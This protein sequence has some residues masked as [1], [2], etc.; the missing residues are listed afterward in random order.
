[1]TAVFFR[2]FPWLVSTALFS[3]FWV[4]AGRF[5]FGSVDLRLVTGWILF[6]L[7]TLLAVFNVRKR[8]SMLP[9]GSASVW[10][11]IHAAA[12]VAALVMFWFHT[13][14]VWP[15]GFYE[16]L[17]TVLFYATS[18][19][20]VAGYFLQRLYPQ[21]LTEMGEEIIYER[22][23]AELAGL[24]EQAEALTLEVVK[25]HGADTIA[26]LYQQRFCWFFERPRFFL[27]HATGSSQKGE[28]WVK[29]RCATVKRYLNEEERSALDKLSGLALR[30]NKIDGHYAL[31][32]VM[33]GWLLIHVPLVASLSV[34]SFWHLLLVHVYAL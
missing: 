2:L 9:L 15:L 29:H 10:L 18:I 30:K 27:A 32:T 28:S 14:T 16:Q 25:K 33:K 6:G 20:G 4:V 5:G 17:I 1:M 24:R 3:V 11:K 8:L 23:P 12:G 22:I 21:R 13:G 7:L 34:L 19:N 31:Q 26:R